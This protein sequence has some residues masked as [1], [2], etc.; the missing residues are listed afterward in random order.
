MNTGQYS[1]TETSGFETRLQNTKV[2][3]QGAIIAD[4]Y[5]LMSPQ[6]KDNNISESEISVTEI[7]KENDYVIMG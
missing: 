4:S 7:S 5:V 2:D 6:L 3:T 1:H